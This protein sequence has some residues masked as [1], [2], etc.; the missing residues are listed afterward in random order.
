MT[1]VTAATLHASEVK[2]VHMT[3]MWD[4]LAHDMRHDGVVANGGLIS[5]WCA[6]GRLADTR[7]DTTRRFLHTKTSPWLWWVDADMGFPPDVVDR[8]LASAD[9]DTHAVMGALCFG[10]KP[11]PD[12]EKWAP[13][14]DPF[15]TLYDWYEDEGKAGFV[16]RENYPRGQVVK[17]DGTGAACLL[18]HRNVLEAVAAEWGEAWFTQAVHPVAGT[19]S[20]DLSFCVRAASVGYGVFVDTSVPTSHEKNVYLTERSYDSSRE[21]ILEAV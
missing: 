18:I 10:Q 6:S 15:P 17:V 14:Y 19:I 2:A 5:A 20:E 21:G 12:A 16:V 4:L 11:N 1:A 3:S 9:P 7:N 13:R 8:L